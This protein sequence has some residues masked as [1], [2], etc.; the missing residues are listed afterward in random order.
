MIAA[1]AALANSRDYVPVALPVLI[2]LTAS[3]AG[4]DLVRRA[5]SQQPIVL[6]NSFLK[7]PME[8]RQPEQPVAKE[9]A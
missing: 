6:G 2:G 8:A 9:V 7:K 4:L 1:N 3:C 5:H